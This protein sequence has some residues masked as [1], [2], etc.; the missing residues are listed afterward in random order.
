M[1]LVSP[2]GGMPEDE[3]EGFLDAWGGEVVAPAYLPG[4]GLH[5]PVAIRF[6]LLHPA[7][8]VALLDLM[9]DAVPGAAERFRAAWWARYPAD[10]RGGG[11]PG[12]DGLGLHKHGLDGRG[13]GGPP[14]V[15]R[16]LSAADRWRLTVV[17]DSAFAAEPGRGGRGWGGPSLDGADWMARARAL[18]SAAA[19]PAGAAMMAPAPLA[20]APEAAPILLPAE[21]AKAMGGA[22]VAK[23]SVPAAAMVAAASLRPG[24]LRRSL[25]LVLLLLV[26]AGGAA[27]TGY[28]PL[29]GDQGLAGG[30]PDGGGPGGVGAGT[31]PG[32]P[33]PAPAAVDLAVPAAG[34]GVAVA[35]EQGAGERFVP[36]V[37]DRPAAAAEGQEEGSA[38]GGLPDAGMSV[39]AAP[40]PEI[41]EPPHADAA[42]L[43]V[44]G[45]GLG[46]VPTP[47]AVP[48]PSLAYE[49]TPLPAGIGAGIDLAGPAWPLAAFP[50]AAFP[51]AALPVAGEPLAALPEEE[52][53][54]PPSGLLGTGLL[55]AGLP[56][57]G[58]PGAGSLGTSLAGAGPPGVG[59]AL[60]ALPAAVGF[61]VPPLP[62]P[63]VVPVAVSAPG[64]P[65]GGP[66]GP[67]APEM[68]AALVRRGDAMMAIGDVS[69]ARLLY[70]RAAAAGSGAAATAL[71]RSY[72][73]AALATLRVRGLRGDA[74]AAAAWYRRGVSLGDP[75]AMGLARR[76]GAGPDAGSAAGVA[77]GPGEGG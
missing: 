65:P 2:A 69:A 39:A 1:I 61:G 49:P 10:G 27:W 71:G 12:L 58:P 13:G 17:L 74:A 7:H 73:P 3:P 68:L 37:A 36:K 32:G 16:S 19:A 45:T 60:P 52:L 29:A 18:L 24:P 4:D 53:P 23:P 28:L 30:G 77:A 40:F 64:R 47:A 67:V 14:V 9:P 41:E 15:Y 70:E 54:A 72:D 8:G 50:V 43:P 25:P 75:E 63:A 59:P 76:L 22:P 44:P 62:G 21:P 33:L 48:L 38:P 34:P 5:P 26:G 11:G 42:P 66:P 46:T 55:G 6:A 56:A 31:A 51:M 20:I 35:Q 57:A